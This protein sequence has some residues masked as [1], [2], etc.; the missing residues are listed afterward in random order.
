M[1]IC[2]EGSDYYCTDRYSTDYSYAW[3]N[4]VYAP[5]VTACAW[6]EI[7]DTYKYNGYNT[8]CA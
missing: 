7:D 4:Q 6:G 5:V 8:A 2:R 3:S 1:W